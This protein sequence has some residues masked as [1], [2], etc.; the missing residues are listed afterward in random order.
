MPFT[1]RV[2]T[3]DE[4]EE[5]SFEGGEAKLGRTADNDVVIK[6]PSSS[7]SHARVYEEDGRY[8]VED[9]KSANGT[10]LN[11]KSLKAPM[12][13]RTGDTITIGDVSLEFSSPEVNDTLMAAPTSTVDDSASDDAG[14]DPNATMLKPPSRPAPA[15][16][17]KPPARRAATP[18]PEEPEEEPDEAADEPEPAEDDNSTRNFEVPPP[19][20]L[21]RRPPSAPVRPARPARGGGDEEE[22]AVQLSAAERARQRRELKKSS[23]GRAQLLWS[24]LSLPA[25]IVVGVVGAAAVIGM[26][27]LII[28]SVIP[29]R[30]AKRVEPVELAANDEPVAESFG[31]GDVDFL[32]PDMKSFTFAYPSP[33]TIVGV[34]HYQAKDCSKV[35]VSIELNGTSVGSIPPDTVDVDKRQL[36]VVLPATVLKPNEPNELVFDN[37]NNPPGDDTWAVWNL[38]VEVIPIPQMTAEDASRRAKEDLERAS[39]MYDQRAIGAM[40]LFRSWKQYRD[41]WLLLEATPDRPAELL[42]IARTRMREIRPELDR[43][44]SAM[45]VDYQK[46]M[47]QKFPNYTMARQVLQNIGAHFEKEHPCLA[48]SRGLLRELDSLDV[49]E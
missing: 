32:R 4:S 19:K 10:K 13:V 28:V 26:L 18:P 34:V 47:N 9:L 16:R 8:F 37:V 48:M 39:R 49:V 14:E 12:E 36:E 3:G 41:A 45:L 17:S 29:K 31:E 1:L 35:E 27:G 6:D 40:N 21:Q 11:N 46:E 15:I 2:T 38:W 23:A 43:K 33:T 30:V 25:K 7:R 20:A 42:S 44:C 22:N 5:F 24:D